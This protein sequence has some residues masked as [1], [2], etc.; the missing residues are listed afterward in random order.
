VSHTTDDRHAQH[1]WHSMHSTQTTPII[2]LVLL[3]HTPLLLARCCLQ[4]QLLCSP[5]PLLP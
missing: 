5:G 3:G 4:Q 1:D 2:A